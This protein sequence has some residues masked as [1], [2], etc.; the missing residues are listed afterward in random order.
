MHEIMCHMT[1]S[2]AWHDSSVWQG[3]KISHNHLRLISMC[4][5]TYTS[6]RSC[7]QERAR[8]RRMEGRKEREGEILS[9]QKKRRRRER[10]R[11]ERN[12]E[13][14]T[15]RAHA[16]V[17]EVYCYCV[18][19]LCIV[20]CYCVLCIAANASHGRTGI[21]NVRVHARALSL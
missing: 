17:R 19:L 8:V 1:H 10:D 12:Q 21:R 15:E 7:V 18:S 2:Y 3:A 16:R 4:D 11:V 5:M 20:Y 13:Q 6:T 14:E 9:E